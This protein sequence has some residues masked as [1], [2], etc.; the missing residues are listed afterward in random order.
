MQSLIDLEKFLK[1]KSV[2]NESV[3]LINLIYSYTVQ[4]TNI[5]ATGAAKS[6]RKITIASGTKIGENTPNI[7]NFFFQTKF[8]L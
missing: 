3:T 8:T 2:A 5:F 6:Y 7:L 4:I 1:K